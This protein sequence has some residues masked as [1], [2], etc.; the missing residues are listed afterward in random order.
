[1]KKLFF[2]LA[3]IFAAFRAWAEIRYIEIES[4]SNTAIVRL[5]RLEDLEFLIGKNNISV[6]FFKKSSGDLLITASGTYFS[7]FLNGYR[8]IDD[9]KKGTSAGFKNGSDFSDAEKHGITSSELYYFF[10]SN[11]FST[12][13]DCSDARKNG[14][15][16]SNQYYAAKEK[17]FSKYS[18][19]SEYLKYT[20]LGYKTKEDWKKAEKKGFSYASYFYDA[21]AKGFSTN[22]D[23]QKA[24]SYNL[25]DESSFKKFCEIEDS[26][27]RIISA[28][29][30]DKRQAFVFYFLVQLPKGESAISVL[31]KSLKNLYDENSSD[32]KNAL[33]KYVNNS[34]YGPTSLFDQDSLRSFFASVKTS[35]LGSY[36]SKTEI[37]KRNGNKPNYPATKKAAN[38]KS[39][40]RNNDENKADAK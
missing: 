22:A 27:E 8:T 11:R 35:E 30:I 16:S 19:Y 7:I 17:G 9:Y 13:A 26:I 38:G 20:E 25:M 4:V 36:S 31:S 34:Y 23:Y 18:D 1:M 5:K 21:Q 33:S 12:V 10:T 39:G 14:F 15:P 40:M 29:T 24:K 2:A 28:K 3:F 32:V 37:F 6:A